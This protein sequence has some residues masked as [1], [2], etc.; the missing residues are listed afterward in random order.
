LSGLSVS[1]TG[2]NFGSTYQLSFYAWVNFNGSANTN[3]LFDNADS[4]GGTHNVLFAVGTSGT[5]PL[6]VGNTT[7]STGA[8]MDCIAFATTGDGGITSDYRIYPKSGTILPLA[9]NLYLAFSYANTASLYTFI[10]PAQFAPAIQQTLS[11]AEYGGDAFNTQAGHTQIGAFGFAWHKVDI[12]KIK[13]N[14][15]WFIDDNFIAGGDFSFVGALGGNNIAI[16][17]SDV[18]TSTTRHPSLLFTLID[19][20]VVTDNPPRPTI[21]ASYSG[22]MLKLSWPFPASGGLNLVSTTNLVPPVTWTPAGVEFITSSNVTSTTLQVT[23]SAIFY[24]LR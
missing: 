2:Q 8:G 12:Y 14:V 6:S 13:N 16:G 1:P 21:T 9:S 7:L 4:E 5:V 17:D 11:T 24:G 18:N 20:L 3:G 15:R 19:N 23:N 22:G 10:F